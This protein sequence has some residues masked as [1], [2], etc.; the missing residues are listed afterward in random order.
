MTE[1]VI[2]PRACPLCGGANACGVAAGAE[3]CWC[4]SSSIS[5][6]LLKQV[7]AP[8]KGRAC[9]CAA[10]AAGQSQSAPSSADAPSDPSQR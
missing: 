1:G 5:G 10:C 9:V 7:P 3:S 4:F 8:V 2:D 6:E